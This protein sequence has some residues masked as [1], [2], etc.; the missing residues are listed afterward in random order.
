MDDKSHFLLRHS[1]YGE[2]LQWAYFINVIL[3]D[4]GYRLLNFRVKNIR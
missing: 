3:N 1:K 2:F 4:V